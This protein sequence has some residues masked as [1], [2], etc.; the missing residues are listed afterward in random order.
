MTEAQPFNLPFDEAIAYFLQKVNM[1]TAFWSEIWQE[2]HA[3]A[4]TVAGAMQEDL[5]NDLRTAVEKG[6]TEGTSLGD[7]KNEFNDIV[8]R[9]GGEEFALEI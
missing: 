6:L 5:L 2:M 8:A 4:F 9:Y 1:P 3:R 7:F